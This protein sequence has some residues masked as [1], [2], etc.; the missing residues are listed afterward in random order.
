[1]RPE[2]L[3][4]SDI[5][6]LFWTRGSWTKTFCGAGLVFCLQTHVLISSCCVSVSSAELLSDWRRDPV[7]TLS[8]F[9]RWVFTWI[10]NGIYRNTDRIRQKP[11]WDSS[12]MRTCL[13]SSDHHGGTTADL[14]TLVHTRPSSDPQ[15]PVSK[16]PEKLSP[17][18]EAS[19]EAIS[20]TSLGGLSAGNCSP[21]EEDQDQ[22]EMGPASPG[23]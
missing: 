20:L 13:L 7:R 6:I 5:W 19:V 4:L 1:M 17:I 21:L 18:Q 10:S 22:E 15:N 11:V 8:S 9:Y 2:D 12:C 23:E 3:I 14:Q 16:I